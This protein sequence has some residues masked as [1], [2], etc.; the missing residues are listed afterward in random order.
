MTGVELPAPAR[1]PARVPR[2][3]RRRA[4]RS[5]S[6]G[7]AWLLVLLVIGAFVAFQIGRQVYVN[8]SI[9]QEAERVRQEIAQLEAENQA[10]RDELEYLNSAAYI[11]A[12]A[13]ALTNVGRPGERILIIP[14]GSEAEL[15]AA[16]EDPAP[17]PAP[18]LE[19]WFRL[20]F[21][22]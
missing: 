18:L 4:Q 5:R 8:W 21:G 6:G 7:S 10:L 11:S 20:F 1:T 2:H 16:A 17:A 15:P 14:P 9:G 3:G 19:Q 22:P 13:R 12:Q